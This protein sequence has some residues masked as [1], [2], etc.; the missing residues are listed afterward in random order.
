MSCIASAANRSTRARGEFLN[1]A[2][3]LRFRLRPR[4]G[5]LRGRSSIN[6]AKRR[7]LPGGF[8]AA[9]F[10]FPLGDDGRRETI[11]DDIHAVRPMSR[12]ASTPR[13]TRIGSTGSAKMEAVARITT[14]TERGDAGHAFAGEHRGHQAW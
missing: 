6:S 13:M 1:V 5:S 14:R 10:A 7:R 2:E 12:R 9:E 8:F 4:S 3:T 11:P